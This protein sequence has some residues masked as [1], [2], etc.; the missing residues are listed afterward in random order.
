MSQD[1]PTS[2]VKDIAIELNEKERHD[3]KQID[4]I[5][6]KLNGD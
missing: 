1:K 4:H 3:A 6:V 5:R 2:I